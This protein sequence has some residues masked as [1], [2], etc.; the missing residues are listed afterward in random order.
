VDKAGIWQWQ[1]IGYDG[2]P[3]WEQSIMEKMAAGK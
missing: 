2:D 1:Q 3:G